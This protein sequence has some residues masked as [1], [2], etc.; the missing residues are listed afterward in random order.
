MFQIIITFISKLQFFVGQSFNWIR[1]YDR[2]CQDF[3]PD[4]I[5]VNSM[6]STSLYADDFHS[7]NIV[8]SL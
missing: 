4:F 5:Y 1:F 2:A 7:Q 3:V 6:I 8:L